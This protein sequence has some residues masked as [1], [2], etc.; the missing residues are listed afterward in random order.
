MFVFVKKMR[1]FSIQSLFL[2][3]FIHVTRT[4]TIRKL[5]LP[6]AVVDDDGFIISRSTIYISG[7]RASRREPH[8]V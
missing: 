7:S 6:D 3:H 1:C 2:A 5:V 8:A 4:K